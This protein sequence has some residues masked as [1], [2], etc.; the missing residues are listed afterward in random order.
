ML[1]A[2]IVGLG[3]FFKGFYKLFPWAE[4]GNNGL[5]IWAVIF[6]VVVPLIAVLTSNR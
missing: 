6:F 5:K 3:L 4:K 1:A 2:S